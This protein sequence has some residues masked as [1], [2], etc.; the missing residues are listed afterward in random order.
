MSKTQYQ[1]LQKLAKQHNVSMA[2]LG[3]RAIAWFLEQNNSTPEEINYVSFDVAHR[4]A[5]TVQTARIVR[6]SAVQRE[7]DPTAIRRS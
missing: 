1:E 6:D 2:W 4:D 7:S 3:R 5:N